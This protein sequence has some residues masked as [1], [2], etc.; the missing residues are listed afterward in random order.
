M[1]EIAEWREKSNALTA[2]WQ[3]EKQ[4]ISELRELKEKLEQTRLEMG[5]P[6]AGRPREGARLRYGEQRQLEEQIRAAEERLKAM[7]SENALLKEEVDAEE[8]AAIVGAGPESRSQAA[9]R[10]DPKAPAHGTGL[11]RA[12]RGQD[13]AVRVVSNAVRRARRSAGS[14]PPDRFVHLFGSNGCRK[15]ELARLAEFLFDDDHAMIR[16]DMSEYQEK[17]TVSRLIGAPPGY[18]GYDEAGS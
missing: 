16:I 18:V 13:D 15:T 9:R 5:A 2:R 14:Q 12:R 11:A 1:E 10:R 8:I 17:H 4:A 3:A 7:Q 6:S